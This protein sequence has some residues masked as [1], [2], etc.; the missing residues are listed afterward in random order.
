MRSLTQT[1]LIGSQLL[2]PLTQ[3]WGVRVGDLVGAEVGYLV[4]AEVGALVGEG[5]GNLVGAG[6]GYLVGA[7]VIRVQV[8]PSWGAAQPAEHQ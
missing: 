5:V 2:L 3:G 1:P 7:A 8:C 6:V 4:G